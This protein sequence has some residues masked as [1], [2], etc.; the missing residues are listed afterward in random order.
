M[1][2]SGVFNAWNFR[3]TIYE[4]GLVKNRNS[5]FDGTC[6]IKATALKWPSRFFDT[7]GD[8]RIEKNGGDLVW[9]EDPLRAPGRWTKVFSS[10]TS[11]TNSGVPTRWKSQQALVKL[12]LSRKR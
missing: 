6:S 1:P 11:Q 5:D 7:F 12:Y 2:E 4:P 3:K 9:R 10:V 8:P